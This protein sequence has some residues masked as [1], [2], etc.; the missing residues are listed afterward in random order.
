MNKNYFLVFSHRT[1][2]VYWSSKENDIPET[3]NT[4][5]QLDLPGL[6][7]FYFRMNSGPKKQ[8]YLYVIQSGVLKQML[9][10]ES[11]AKLL[12]KSP[13]TIDKSFKISIF[14]NCQDL[15]KE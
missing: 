6:E 1:L 7:T 10:S 11:P 8:S 5:S 15:P 13:T 2:N 12:V 4:R 3:V 14:G 9:M